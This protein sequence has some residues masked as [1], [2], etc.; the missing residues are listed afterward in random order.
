M[1]KE[2]EEARKDLVPGVPLRVEDRA[3]EAN[4]VL[5]RGRA[6]LNCEPLPLEGTDRGP[7]QA[8][9]SN[10]LVHATKTNEALCEAGERTLANASTI[11]TFWHCCNTSFEK[12]KSFANLYKM[13]TAL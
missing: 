5:R 10:G 6:P 12:P 7:A 9:A 8:G 2:A 4:Q 13:G 11:F 3:L 1:D